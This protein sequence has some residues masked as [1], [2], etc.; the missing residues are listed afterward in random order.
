MRRKANNPT[1]QETLVHLHRRFSLAKTCRAVGTQQYF[2]IAEDAC[3]RA[4]NAQMDDPCLWSLS[5][6]FYDLMLLRE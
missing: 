6:F 2:E 5:A 1:R 3:G 4:S